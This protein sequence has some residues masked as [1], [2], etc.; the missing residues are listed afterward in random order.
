MTINS[1]IQYSAVRTNDSV[2]LISKAPPA[3]EQDPE[4]DIVEAG[5]TQE[6]RGAGQL[7]GVHDREGL[8]EGAGH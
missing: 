3:C 1:E 5:D 2:R 6:D 7:Q 8:G 4:L